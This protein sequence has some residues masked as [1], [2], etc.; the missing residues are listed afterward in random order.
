MLPVPLES[1]LSPI[2]WRKFDL[3]MHLLHL[4]SC[5]VHD[6]HLSSI[7]YCLYKMIVFNQKVMMHDLVVNC[8]D[9]NVGALII[10]L[11]QEPF[12][13]CRDVTAIEP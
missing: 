9:N 1:K 5:N 6:N 4:N 2:N 12:V 13:S 3:I 7:V 10:I 8:T 11:L